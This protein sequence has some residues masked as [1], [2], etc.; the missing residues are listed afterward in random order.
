MESKVPETPI[1]GIVIIPMELSKATANIVFSV[2][3]FCDVIGNQMTGPYIFFFPSRL[4]S[5]IYANF[6][7]MNCQHSYRMFQRI[8]NA[9]KGINN[10]AVLR[11]VTRSLV[12][13]V[14]KC[15]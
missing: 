14:R 11:K 8:L 3:V 6:G 10:A 7:N 15:I 2:E 12:T 13:P 5:D 4:T 1:Y 9:A